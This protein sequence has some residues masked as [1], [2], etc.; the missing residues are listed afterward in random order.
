MWCSNDCGLAAARNHS[1]GFAQAEALKRDDYKCKR[2]GHQGGESY[3]DRGGK[4]HHYRRGHGMEVN[5]IKPLV[6]RGYHNGCVHHQENLET[7]CHTCHVSVTKAQRAE[8][9]RA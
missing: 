7:L 2:C 6:G 9:K 3:T 1:W 4:Q 8:R 5:H